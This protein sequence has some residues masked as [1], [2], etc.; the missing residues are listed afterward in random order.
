MHEIWSQLKTWIDSGDAFAIATVVKARSPSPRGIGSVLAIS[1]DGKRF[2][3]SVSAGCVE[4]EVIE[5]AQACLKDG[6]TRWSEFG[7]SQGFPWE[8]AFSCG[9]K[10]TVRVDRFDYSNSMIQALIDLHESHGSGI[11]L[12][13]EGQQ[14]LLMEDGSFVGDKDAWGME[15][16]S[17]AKEILE[18]GGPTKEIKTLAGK[19]LLRH[20]SQPFRLFIIGAGHI[21]INLVHLA[22]A[23]NYQTIMIDPR[24]SFAQ[25]ERFENPPDRLIC[26]WPENALSKIQLTPFDSLVALTHDPKIDDQALK[27][28]LKSKASYIGALGSTRSHEVRLKRLA[29]EA[30]DQNDLARIHGPVG[31][32]IGSSTPAEIALSIIAEMVQLKNRENLEEK[33]QTAENAGS[34][35]V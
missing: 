11:W 4:T 12:S 6:Q 30:I 2:I 13:G 22:K 31:L 1:A 29:S 25:D 35:E 7:P 34:A 16:L 15:C 18:L 21:S 8:V 5:L 28:A 3:G 32:D 14:G 17:A 27:I 33:K 10:I 26:A 24:E 9:G 23:L 19:V 20:V